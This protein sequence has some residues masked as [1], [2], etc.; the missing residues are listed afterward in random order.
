MMNKIRR[1]C[2]FHDT[3]VETA[4]GQLD[5]LIARYERSGLLNDA[6]YAQA[7]VSRLR[8]RGMSR[9]AVMEKLQI[10]GLSPTQIKTALAEMEGETSDEDPEFTAALALARRKK[11][12]PFRKNPAHDDFKQKDMAALGRA[13]YSFDVARRVMGFRE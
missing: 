2:K 4:T 1:S 9:R 8:R 5:D 7:N 11:I 12:G 13:G 10:K 6:Q 3:D